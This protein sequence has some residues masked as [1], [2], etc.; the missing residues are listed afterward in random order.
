MNGI[1]ILIVC[2]ALFGFLPLAIFLYRQK[3]ANRVLAKG[4]TTRAVIYYVAQNMKGTYDT[5][6][7]HFI[8][9][10]GK[11]YTGRITTGRNEHK[12]N[13]TIEVFYLPDNPRHNTVR[14]A[15]KSTGFL[16]FVILIGIAVSFMMYKVYEAMNP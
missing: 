6:D 7:Y 8:A 1:N 11:Q 9:S 15:W 4:N 3:R 14:G 10:D 12:I 2:V 16:I 5:V 13:D